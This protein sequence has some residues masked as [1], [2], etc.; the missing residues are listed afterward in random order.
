[1]GYKRSTPDCTSPVAMKSTAWYHYS[2]SGCEST[3]ISPYAT[4]T[5]YVVA[6]YKVLWP[7]L[8]DSG[9]FLSLT[10]LARRGLIRTVQM[11]YMEQ[12]ALYYPWVQSI[13]IKEKSYVHLFLCPGL[14]IVSWIS[15]EKLFSN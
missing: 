5:I 3:F 12:F 15:I 14:S 7:T 6:F 13:S 8:K 4:S 2:D 11:L 9:P 10:S 1:M